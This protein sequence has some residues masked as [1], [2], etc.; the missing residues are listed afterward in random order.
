MKKFLLILV[1]VGGF[2]SSCSSD[3]KPIEP[4]YDPI[5]GNW[6]MIAATSQFNNE[7][8]VNDFDTC[9]ILNTYQFNGL[10]VNGTGTIKQYWENSTTYLC[11]LGATLNIEWENRG[12]TSYIF[13]QTYDNQ[14]LIEEINITFENNKMFI[15]TIDGPYKFVQTLQ[16]Q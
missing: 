6:K 15:T 14:I 8:P 9:D 13:K 10:R 7:P 2:L 5:L 16:K 12:N 3:D 4:Q 1:L 11:E